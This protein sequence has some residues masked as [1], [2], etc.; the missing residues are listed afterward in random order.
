MT[1]LAEFGPETRYYVDPHG[2]FEITVT[3]LDIGEEGEAITGS[4]TLTAVHCYVVDWRPSTLMAMTEVFQRVRDTL[5]P[6][7]AA[8]PYAPSPKFHKFITRWGFF[9]TV[10]VPCSD[11]TT[12]PLYFHTN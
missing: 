6:I 8:L 5:P 1:V 9:R 11:G 4:N 3:P 10:D 12:R 7:I 2:R